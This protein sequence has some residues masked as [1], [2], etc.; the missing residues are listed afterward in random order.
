MLCFTFA[1]CIGVVC[2]TIDIIRSK[3]RYLVEA[4]ADVVPDDYLDPEPEVDH[5]DVIDKKN[6][7]IE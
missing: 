1:T 5:V 3:K 4:S 2:A 7:V 6:K